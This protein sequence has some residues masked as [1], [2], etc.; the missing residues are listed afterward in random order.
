MVLLTPREYVEKGYDEVFKVVEIGFGY[1]ELLA[2]LYGY[3][4]IPIFGVDIS[5]FS[6]EKAKGKLRDKN[7]YLIKTDGYFFVKYMN[8]PGSIRELYILF[9]D[10]WPKAPSRRLISVDFVKLV[11]SRVAERVY[12]ATDHE[13]YCEE[14]LKVFMDS[15]YFEVE[16]WEL[17]IS[18]KYMRKWLSIGRSFKS[19]CFVKKSQSIYEYRKALL[20]IE[21]RFADIDIFRNREFILK[22]REVFE[23]EHSKRIISYLYCEK[24][25]TF[26]YYFKVE[27]NYLRSLNTCGEVLPPN[28]RILVGEDVP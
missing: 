16:N 18:T 27:N 28:M 17:P 25:F 13:E 14:I 15:G 24:N 19:F 21:G 3:S 5:N 8:A 10:P 6:F 26:N 22:K 23:S 4:D 11:A 20:S 9:P 1:G 7:V 12:I 2:Y